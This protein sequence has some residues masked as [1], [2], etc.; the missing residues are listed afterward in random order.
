VS[1]ATAIRSTRKAVQ[2]YRVS[3][4]VRCARVDRSTVLCRAWFRYRGRAK[5]RLVEVW[6]DTRGIYCYFK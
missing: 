1:T 5:T 4:R 3:S 6:S 2:R